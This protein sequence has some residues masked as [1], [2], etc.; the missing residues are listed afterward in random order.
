MIVSHT[1]A[2]E[3]TYP[4]PHLRTLQ[5]MLWERAERQQRETL[6]NNQQLMLRQSLLHNTELKS[7]LSQIHA[8]TA[9]VDSPPL[10]SSLKGSRPRT[11]A[12]S[13]SLTTGSVSNGS[14]YGG[15]ALTR[16]D[17]FASVRSTLS[18]TFF[19]AL[20]DVSIH[21]TVLL[22]WVLPGNG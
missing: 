11:P 16:F 9:D 20:D 5:C 3:H 22:K 15:K 8:L 21:V 19:D 13:Q 10:T 12:H 1:R 7:R 17:S 6:F 18:E 4:H 2:H 14:R